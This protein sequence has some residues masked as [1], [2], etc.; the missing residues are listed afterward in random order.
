MDIKFETMT[1][2]HSVEV[3]DIFNYYVE[4]SFAA[5]LEQKLPYEFF[6]R[7]L[8]MAGGYPSYDKRGRFC[9]RILRILQEYGSPGNNLVRCCCEP[10]TPAAF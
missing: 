6:D 3:M 4:N 1:E 10:E 9:C 5:Y 8:G 2:E 7:L